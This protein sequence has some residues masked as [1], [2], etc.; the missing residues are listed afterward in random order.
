M[1]QRSGQKLAEAFLYVCLLRRT[2]AVAPFSVPCGF[3]RPLAGGKGAILRF[4]G[5]DERGSNVIKPA[6]QDE[7]HVDGLVARTDSAV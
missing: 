5:E 7:G 1:V 2:L 4:L 6:P 3:D